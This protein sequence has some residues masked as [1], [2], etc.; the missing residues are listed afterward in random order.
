MAMVRYI[1][2]TTLLF[3]LTAC[4]RTSCFKEVF[5]L[6][7]APSMKILHERCHIEDDGSSAKVIYFAKISIKDNNAT[8]LAELLNL[9]QSEGFN[10]IVP[11]CA[12][13]GNWW[14]IP[15]PDVQS[16]IKNR[17]S[18]VR[19]KLSINCIQYGQSVY[20]AAQ[21]IKPVISTVPK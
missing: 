10:G 4:H 18:A 3:A 13:C 11:S 19:G 5:G 9:R 17:F 6:D 21:G 15:T 16:K 20:L 1:I 14:D 2:L 7:I 8:L 12:S